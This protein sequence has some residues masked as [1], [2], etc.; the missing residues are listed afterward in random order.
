LGERLKH[1][2]VSRG[3][4]QDEYGKLFGVTK[5]A[6]SLWESD[7][8]DPPLNTLKALATKWRI[9]IDWLLFGDNVESIHTSPDG[10]TEKEISLCLKIKQHPELSRLFEQA[11]DGINAME[12]IKSINIANQ[13]NNTSPDSE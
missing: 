11:I 9:S 12:R 4:S 7:N 13:D 6:V 8:R 10:L 5:T 1:I 3:L 2:R